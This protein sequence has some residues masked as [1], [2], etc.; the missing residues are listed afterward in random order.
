MRL[1]A[2]PLPKRIALRREACTYP[3]YPF[4][5]LPWELKLFLDPNLAHKFT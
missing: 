4:P 5:N 3:Q 1:P 2:N